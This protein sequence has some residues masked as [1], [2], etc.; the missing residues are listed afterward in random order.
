MNSPLDDAMRRA[1]R[2]KS[3]EAQQQRHWEQGKRDRKA[4]FNTL[5]VDFLA[6]MEQQNN[7]GTTVEFKENRFRKIKAW[8]LFYELHG[9]ARQ[10]FVLTIDGRIPDRNG[11]G[12]IPFRSSSLDLSNYELERL[13]QS[14]AELLTNPS[15]LP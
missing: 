14:M 8:R 15:V 12:P 11:P 9:D 3:F 10:S 7:K 5:V 2:D 13:A 6:R 1:A 4:K